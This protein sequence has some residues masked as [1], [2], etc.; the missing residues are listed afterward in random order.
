MNL[1]IKFDPIS[2]EYE[3]RKVV[4]G[5]DNSELLYSSENK[6]AVE[7]YLAKELM[8]LDVKGHNEVGTTLVSQ[9]WNEGYVEGVHLCEIGSRRILKTFSEDEV[10]SI[11]SETLREKEEN[12][13][14][15]NVFK[16]KG[17]SHIFV[18]EPMNDYLDC[19]GVH[20]KISNSFMDKWGFDFRYIEG[21]EDIHKDNTSEAVPFF[22]HS[23]LDHITSLDFDGLQEM[24]SNCD[25][26]LE[27]LHKIEDTDHNA[28]ELSF[29]PAREL[30]SEYLDYCITKKQIDNAKKM[31]SEKGQKAKQSTKSNSP[32]GQ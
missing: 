8:H 30:E 16:L 29:L 24:K 31:V 21:S 3:L 25:V 6:Q 7:Y 17:N 4:H 10:T 18:T 22:P 26:E 19:E 15:R 20:E 9:G 28:S 14:F 1:R 11:V 27:R 12:E 32:K 5:M 2:I 23:V 13:T